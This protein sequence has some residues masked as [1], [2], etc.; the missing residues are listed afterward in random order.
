ML[1]K[2]YSCCKIATNMVATLKKISEWS[3][4][5]FNTAVFTVSSFSRNRLFA[6]ITTVFANFI[7]RILVHM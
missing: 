2:K 4:V 5:F 7:H 1:E 3:F 6:H